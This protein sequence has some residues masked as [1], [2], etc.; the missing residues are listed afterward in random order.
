MEAFL[1]N[2]PPDLTDQS[3]RKE[4][5]PFMKAL[6]IAD[7][8]C[9]KP[10][11]KNLAWISFLHVADGQRF[12]EKHGKVVEA[13]PVT[14]KKREP[15]SANVESGTPG[16]GPKTLR[17]N[18]NTKP[19]APEP[20][21]PH[22]LRNIPRL[23]I[24]KKP[25]YVER[26]YR[27]IN[28]LT[29]SH[30]QHEQ[31]QRT[32]APQRRPGNE[33]VSFE[34]RHIACGHNVFA[35]MTS[36]VLTFA[37]QCA[38]RT[39]ATARLTQRSLSIVA[40][41]R[42]RIDVACEAIVD[43][44]AGHN[45]RSLTLVLSEPPRF[46]AAANQQ[47]SAQ[48]P[49][50]ERRGSCPHWPDHAKYADHCLVYQLGTTGPDFDATVRTI[51][52]R[53]LISVTQDTL[54]VDL[55][56]EP[57]VY[58]YTSSMAEFDGKINRGPTAAGRLP[59][60][61]LFQIQ[62]LVWNNYLHPSEG[63]RMLDK[64][65][66]L[67]V[68]ARSRRNA[69]PLTVDS[70]KKLFQQIPYRCPGT[71]PRDVDVDE[72]VD[73]VVRIEA[74]LRRDDLQRDPIYGQRIPSHQAW[75]M[76]AMVTPS[77]IVLH[78]PE[79]ESKNRILRKFPRFTD[80]FL[81]CLFC[82]DNGQDLAFHPN[83]AHDA[84]YERYRRVLREGVQVAGRRF[85]FLGFSHSSLRSHSAWFMAP[86]TDDN[87]ELQSYDSIV[88]SLGRFEDIRVPA[89][90]AARIG[91]AFSETPYAVPIFER[92]IESRQVPDVKNHDG[93]R[94][95][96][97]GVG[98]LSLAAMREFQTFLPDRAA[99]ATCFQIRWGGV[100]GMLS[101]DTRLKG[102]VFC[103]R[104]ESML[105][106]PSTDLSEL[107]I[108]DAAS[109]PLR[110]ML[111]RQL[112]KI[113]EDMG[114]SDE[115][116]MALQ[117][118]ELRVLRAVTAQ[119]ANTSTFLR[120]QLIGT[121][122]GF[123]AF[124]RHMGRLDIEYRRDEF[125][126]T[127][128]EHAVLRELRLLKHKARIPVT[129]GVTLFGI[130]DETGVLEEGQIFLTFDRSP[131]IDRPPPHGTAAVITRSP[132]LHPGDVR[133]VTVVHPPDDSPLRHLRNCVVFSQRGERDLPSQLSGGDLDGDLYNIIWDPAALPQRVFHPAD[134]P[135]VEPKPL[136]RDVTRDDIADFFINFMKTD[137]L[138]MIATRHQIMADVMD[139]GTRVGDCI[140]LAEMHSTAVDSSKTGI[141]V[142]VRALPRAPR[143]RPDL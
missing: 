33:A 32:Q 106:F 34:I 102:K 116:F 28:K 131:L 114:T 10:R 29:L 61:L 42:F 15:R 142:D 84:V 1:R 46:Y 117:A 11:R 5:E 136:D 130:M 13:V 21:S 91:Q 66:R 113:M 73:R 139:E 88:R 64:V 137:V 25:I 120:H 70:L 30:L 20:A 111:N 74:D 118:R 132:A 22:R 31:H 19:D 71:E 109:K 129:G 49:K 53:D 89:K 4:L 122:M 3:L 16:K 90:C 55:T 76:K 27:E 123:P 9:D 126:R 40:S 97:D 51:K 50:W 81:R 127:V 72:L 133:V 38:Y 134:Y 121:H 105:K 37:Q 125:L 18:K 82:D 112:I 68:D 67:A 39:S 80:F 138:G 135:R 24:T 101:L 48:T 58:D 7:W 86:F 52:N 63:T 45:D 41:G 92:D 47:G 57:F 6:G 79:P 26:S 128:V 75:V 14:Q 98:T 35:S 17:D 94:V 2:V 54:P 107:G 95:F 43:F 124:I 99:D 103:V 12:I 23:H 8:M 56:P 65:E 100:K 87:W 140:A 119:V 62:A 36:G 69:L 44:I 104:N 59:F 110:L 115:W 93:S 60:P 77:R 78:G 141:P 108:C 96:S 83:V 143:T 85:S